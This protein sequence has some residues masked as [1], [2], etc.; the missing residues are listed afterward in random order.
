[1]IP[2]A[3]NDA[4]A[5]VLAIA[6]DAPGASAILEPGAEPLTFGALADEVQR[7]TSRL[8]EWGVGR[9]DVVVFA[10]G[11]RSQT[12]VA[13]AALPATS[14]LALLN[15]AATFDALSDL[16]IRLQPKAVIVPAGGESTIR[17]AARALD[18]TEVVAKRAVRHGAGVFDLALAR[19]TASLDRPPRVRADWA[20]L[21]ATS[22]TTGR[23]KIVSHGHRQIVATARAIG[24]RLNL[25]PTDI[26]ANLMPFHLAGG[27]RNGF[28]QPL[29][30]GAAV[31]VLPAADIDAFVAAVAAGEV[32]CTSAS[33][34]MLRELLARLVAG[35]PDSNAAGCA[36]FAWHRGASSPPRWTSS[37]GGSACP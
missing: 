17:R 37:S 28:F 1:M 12:A 8:R 30:N 11:E 20:C 2:A 5:R 34:S 15:P 27:I 14:T 25:G 18:L 31:N 10:N 23:P 4:T 16:L 33:F 3:D 35:A 13:L 24:E 19:A 29:L 9:G 7:V 6:K 22:G 26:L 32:T 21:G 36:T